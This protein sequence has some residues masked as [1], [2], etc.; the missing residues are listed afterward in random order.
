MFEPFISA[1]ARLPPPSSPLHWGCAFSSRQS[2]G[3]RTSPASGSSSWEDINDL[4]ELCSLYK[5][6]A[7]EK[8]SSIFYGGNQIEFQMRMS[9]ASPAL[10]L[11]FSFFKG[12]F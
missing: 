7:A 12:L 2:T 1:P 3:E 6:T 5:H 9:W 8:S 11:S 10:E 4:T